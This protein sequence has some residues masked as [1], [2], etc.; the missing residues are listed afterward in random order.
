MTLIQDEADYAAMS[1]VTTERTDALLVQSERPYSEVRDQAKV[2]DIVCC[3]DIA[4]FECRDTDQK[5]GKRDTDSPRPALSVM[6]GVPCPVGM[7]RPA[8]NAAATVTGTGGTAL[9]SSVR[10]R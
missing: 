9:V 7:I 6:E 1:A 4:E 10:K 8:R 5:I 3:Y 2:A